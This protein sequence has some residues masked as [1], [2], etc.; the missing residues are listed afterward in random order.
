MEDIIY[1]YAVIGTG[2]S[3]LGVLYNIK[4]KNKKILVVESSNAIIKKNFQ[5]P[6]Y[7]DEKIPIPI[8]KNFFGKKRPFFELL[9]Y[10]SYGG[11]T[12]FWGGY[13]CRFNEDDLKKWPINIRHLNKYYRQAEKILNLKITIQHAKKDLLISKS[14]IAKKNN[15]IF[16]S[17]ELISKLLKRKNIDIKFKEL[18]YFKKKRNIF[19]LNLKN[20]KKKILCKKIILCAGVYGTQEILKNSI[21]NINFKNVKQAQSFII[22]VISKDTFESTKIDKQVILN[23]KGKHGNIYFELKKDDILLKKTLKQNVSF[24]HHFLPRFLQKKIAIVWGFIPS[25]FSYS[26]KLR[27][28]RVLINAVNIKKKLKTLNYISSVVN[29]LRERLNL[30]VLKQTIKLNQFARSYHV[31]SN[32]PMDLKKKKFL[33]TNIN[34]EINLPNYK[35]IFVSGSS[36]FPDLPSKSHGLTILANSLRIGDYLNN[37]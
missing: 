34:G 23:S 37:D 19:Y 6:I 3:S 16:N 21:K 28:N 26:Y 7:C 33:T 29:V 30:I 24:L 27:K 32:I 18:D 20:N 9:N 13:C 14:K 15:Q 22:P 36:V 4:K 12:N 31:G 25:E 1:D 35:N 5:K 17:S 2:L 10:K 8:S 11:N